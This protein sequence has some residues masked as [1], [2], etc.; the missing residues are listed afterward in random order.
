MYVLDFIREESLNDVAAS[1]ETQLL[2]GGGG[3]GSVTSGMAIDLVP[4]IWCQAFAGCKVECE[5]EPEIQCD[6]SF[7]R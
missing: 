6:N 4:A 3:W 5:T 2:R 7:I 1:A